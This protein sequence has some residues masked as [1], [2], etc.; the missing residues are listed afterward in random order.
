MD[1]DE[2]GPSIRAVHNGTRRST[3]TAALNNN[4]NR[5]GAVDDWGDWRGE[6]RS[7]RLGAPAETQ[8]DAPPPK[9]A[10]TTESNASS[11]EAISSIVP[12]NGIKLKSN[13]AAAVKPTE[14]LVES[15]AGKKKSRFWVYAVE[16]IAAPEVT[17]DEPSNMDVEIESPTESKRFNGY[18]DKTAASS[19]TDDADRASVEAETEG[20]AYAKSTEGSLSPTSSM[21]ES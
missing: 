18:R 17:V 10:R 2:A 20:D 14:T 11:T 9:R 5:A 4:G 1:E 13:G 19:V 16:P 12:Q 3:R 7:A 6:R 15:V 8:L 21:D